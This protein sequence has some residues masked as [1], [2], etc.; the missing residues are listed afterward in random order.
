MR[1]VH[2]HR[3]TQIVR[4]QIYIPYSR[5]PREHLSFVLRAAGDPTAL[6]GAVRRAV[7]EVDGDLAVAKVRPL[8]EYLDRATRPARFSMVLATIFGGLALTLAAIG[9]Y[10]VVATSVAQRR[11]ELGVRLALGATPR[12]LTRQVL[13]EGLVMALAGLAVGAVG[14]IAVS[15]LIRAL[16]FGV[17]PLDPWAYAAAAVVLPLATLVAC[18]LPARRAGRESPMI[19]LRSE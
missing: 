18:W 12:D 7:A 5:A 11:R 17:G 1:H 16:L 19:A 13:R 15:R 2:H 10:G 4:G 8:A 14:A 6:A 9:I 3:L